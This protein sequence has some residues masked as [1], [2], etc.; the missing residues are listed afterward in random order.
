[1]IKRILSF[2][3]ASSSTFREPEKGFK[4]ANGCHDVAS[5]ACQ[6]WKLFR[7][8]DGCMVE[9]VCLSHIA[10]CRIRRFVSSAQL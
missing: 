4:T 6:P 2:S 8:E 10:F 5:P 7:E 9:A 3:H 1:M